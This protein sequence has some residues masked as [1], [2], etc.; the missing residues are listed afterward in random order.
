MG[1][2]ENPCSQPPAGEPGCAHRVAAPFQDGEEDS[3]PLKNG[4]QEWG[5]DNSTTFL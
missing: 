2:A 1:D 5:K 4:T 3:R